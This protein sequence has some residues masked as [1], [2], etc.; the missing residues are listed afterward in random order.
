MSRPGFPIPDDYI[1]TGCG[2]TGWVTCRFY[3][4]T[5]VEVAQKKEKYFEKYPP[6]GY[7]THTPNNVYKHPNG[8]YCIE[9]QRWSS[10]N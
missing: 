2:R 8:Y 1:E 5:I 10:C 6:E 3:G 9:V 4:D 7:D